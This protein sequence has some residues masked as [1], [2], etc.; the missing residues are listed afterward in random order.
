MTRTSSEPLGDIRVRHWPDLS[1]W[2]HLSFVDLAAMPN[3]VREVYEKA[4]PRLKAEQQSMMI[5]A[6]AFPNMKESAQKSLIRRVEKDMKSGLPRPPV[7][8]PLPP[9]EVSK[10]AEGLG[11]GM[12]FVDAEGEP[13]EVENIGGRPHV[14]GRPVGGGG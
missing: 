14:N 2:Y 13:V 4:L 6:A 3:G 12:T 11:I 9:Q 10:Q 1:F 5:D 7:P 8:K